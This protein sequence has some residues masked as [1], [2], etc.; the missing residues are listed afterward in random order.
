MALRVGMPAAY[1]QR[2]AAVAWCG[3]HAGVMAHHSPRRLAHRTFWVMSPLAW[4]ACLLGWLFMVASDVRTVLVSGPVIFV[5][6][7]LTLLAAVWLRHR[8]GMALGAMHAG[9][10]M[11]FAMLVNV[12]S[13]GPRQAQRPFFIMGAMHVLVSACVTAWAL[14]T[15]PAAW[16]PTQCQRCG[17]SLRGLTSSRCPECGEPVPGRAG[18]VDCASAQPGA[19]AE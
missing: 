4:I 3:D 14:R 18:Q 12:L 5:C 9:V 15:A 19:G 6:G 11:L 8:P 16:D 2:L 1:R 7:L 10:V 17:Y 13:W